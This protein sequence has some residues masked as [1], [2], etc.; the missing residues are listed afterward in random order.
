MAGVYILSADYPEIRARL[1]VYFDTTMLSDEII[2]LDTFSGK[3]E[4]DIVARLKTPNTLT[5]AQQ[6]KVKRACI[7]RAAAELVDAVPLQ[8]SISAD[9]V[10][11]QHETVNREKLKMSLYAASDEEVEDIIAETSDDASGVSGFNVFGTAEG[12]RGRWGYSTNY[13]NDSENR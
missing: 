3:A 11:I 1:G 9:D 8:K 2:A 10:Q 6:V 13:R 12:E 5:P 4:D 7:L